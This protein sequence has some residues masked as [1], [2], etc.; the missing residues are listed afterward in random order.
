VGHVQ[1]DP[2]PLGSGRVIRPAT[3]ADLPAVVELLL[4]DEIE[5]RRGSSGHTGTLDRYVA[6]FELISED[7]N[8]ELLVVTQADDDTPLA[9]MQLV[10]IAGL[11]WQASLRAQLQGVRVTAA[12]RGTGVGSE[13]LLW[14][15]SRAR[16]RGASVLQL[17]SN[18]RRHDAHRWYAR[19]G[20]AQSHTG[21]RLDLASQ[22]LGAQQ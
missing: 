3:M 21:F 18:H 20:F 13:M 7:R 9:T 17:S 15:M 8:I 5:R 11:T 4:A 1:N 22:P 6:A 14:A 12:E 19:M 2:E 16:Q 10:Y